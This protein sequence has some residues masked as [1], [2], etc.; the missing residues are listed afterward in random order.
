MRTEARDIEV[1]GTATNPDD[2]CKL[3]RELDPDLILLDLDLG[4]PL[5]GLS[6]LPKLVQDG[7]R[8]VL[9]YTGLRDTAAHRQAVLLGARGVLH[10][11]SESQL[12]LKAI[13]C[14]IAG[15]I[16]LDRVTTGH[17]LST[18]MRGIDARSTTVSDPRI[19]K[20][21]RREREIV[22]SIC[23]HAGRPAKRMASAL[24]ISDHTLRNHLSAIYEK[25]GVKNRAE[26]CSFAEQNGLAS[27]AEQG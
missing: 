12:V 16:W 10:K 1:V 21:T 8:R 15:E 19:G 6:V 24:K 27:F 7:K 18:L 23:A 22:T 3:A 14:V 2:A 17:I 25:L 9:I 26:L 5:D 20:L 4:G 11:S 13:R